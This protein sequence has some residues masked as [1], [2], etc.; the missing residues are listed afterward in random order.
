MALALLRPLPRFP[1]PAH[2]RTVADAAGT[3]VRIPL[4]F[5][6]TVLAWASHPPSYL[7]VTRAP[8]TLLVAGGR[9]YISTREAFARSELSW[10]YPQVLKQDK[11]WDLRGKLASHGQ[12]AAI[13]NILAYDQGAAYLGMQGGP[14]PLMRTVGLSALYT[15]AGATG[16][17]EANFSA[18]RV[19]SALAGEPERGEVLIARFHQIHADLERELQSAR[20]DHKLRVAYIGSSKKDRRFVQVMSGRGDTDSP[21]AGLQNVADQYY[22]A[23][24][25]S[26]AE[27]VLA[28]DS[29]IVFLIGETPQ[30]FMEDSRWVGLKAVRERRVYGWPGF[31]SDPA[32][33]LFGP[34]WTRWK[35]ENVYPDR[36]QLKLRQMFRDLFLREFNYPV[37]EEQIDSYFHLD[38]N[39]HSAGY[40]RFAR[41]YQSSN[42]QRCSK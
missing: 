13:E 10:I 4:P 7:A 20:I 2:S 41:S 42:E 33:I 5:R 31:G 14:M 17:D 12:Y 22:A 25:R 11:F 28:T 19:L 16:V 40:E 38:K 34:L 1:I 21:R 24:K 3:P 18:A 30:E 37:T 8:E 32:Y 6:G 9:R 15:D 35:A 36:L 27:R 26:D 39:Q 29:D 23:T